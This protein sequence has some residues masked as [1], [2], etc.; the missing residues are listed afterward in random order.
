MT[1]YI[2]FQE[3]EEA[4]RQ[5][6]SKHWTS[7]KEREQREEELHKL[8]G[9]LMPEVGMGCTE[10]LWSDRRAHTVVEVLSPNKVAVR[11]NKTVCKD[12]FADEYE[13]LDELQGGA[14]VYT[15]RRSGRWVMEGQPDRNGSVVLLLGTRYHSIDPSF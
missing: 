7:L 10:I 11:E 15:R 9:K 13:I 2:T 8:Y 6:E 5:F 3:Y 1:K 12:Y 4:R 14:D